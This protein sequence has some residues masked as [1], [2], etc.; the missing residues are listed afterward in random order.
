MVSQDPRQQLLLLAALG[1]MLGS[2]SHSGFGTGFGQGTL[3]GQQALQVELD[4]RQ[5]LQ[6]QQQAQVLT[7]QKADAAEQ[8]DRQKQLQGALMTIEARVKSI[9]DKETYD[10]EI[11]GYANTLRASGYRLDANWL[12]QAVPFTKPTAEKEAASVIDKFLKNPA[13]TTLIQQ[14]PDQLQKVMVSFDVDGDGIPEQVPLLR[15]AQIAKQPFAVDASGQLITYPKGTTL[16]NKADADGIFQTLLKQAVAEGKNPEDPAV[17]L[18]L[19]QQALEMATKDK[20]ASTD[21]NYLL[22]GRPIVAQRKNG[23]LMYRGSDVTDLV[24]PYVPPKDAADKLVKVEHQDPTTGKAV[25]EWLPQS[26]VRGK[27][28]V[29]PAGQ[30][31]ENRLASA[32]AV[33]QTGNDIIAQLSDPAVAKV[34]G[35]LMGRASSLRDFIGNPPPQ[36]A[37]LAG[38][39]ESFALANM[40]VHGMRSAQGAEQIKKLLDGHHTPESLIAAIRGLNK[41]SSHFMENEGVPGRSAPSSTAPTDAD[42]AGAAQILRS[43]G[44]R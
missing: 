43:R 15:V 30:T 44:G 16:E 22:N 33:T 12:R 41:F 3:A 29:K 27:T 4:K 25:I 32:H 18:P 5:A 20:G 28:F 14:H 42:L 24:T 26:E 19:Q 38:S 6:R 9:P 2:G 8:A 37:E 13:N 36:Y 34:L 21:A 11:E 10:T 23:K 1:A 31:V 40:G 7:Q 17:R 39:I 35:P